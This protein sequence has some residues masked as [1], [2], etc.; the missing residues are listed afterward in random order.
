MVR[1]IEPFLRL[2]VGEISPFHSL[3]QGC[4]TLNECKRLVF[5]NYPDSSPRKLELICFRD[6]NVPSVLRR[7]SAAGEEEIGGAWECSA[8]MRS[9]TCLSTS[10]FHLHDGSGP[11]D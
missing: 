10:R 9:A 6:S 2:V 7:G 1:C 11:G 4:P 5:V 8:I 3:T